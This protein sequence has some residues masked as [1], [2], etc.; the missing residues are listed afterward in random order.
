[1]A[2]F[3]ISNA[4][5]RERHLDFGRILLSLYRI[6]EIDITNIELLRR[7]D[8]MDIGVDRARLQ[9]QVRTASFGKVAHAADNDVPASIGG[10]EGCGQRI[11]A[12]VTTIRDLYDGAIEI[13]IESIGREIK[14][15][16]GG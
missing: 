1:M 14:G 8:R 10:V 7:M 2:G 16:G 9:L 13:V 6:G 3:T 4:M 12:G 15:P 11:V 5:F